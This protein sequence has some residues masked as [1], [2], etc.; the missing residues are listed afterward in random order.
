MKEKNNYDSYRKAMSKDEYFT[1]FKE[2][3]VQKIT[4]EIKEELYQKY[5]VKCEVFQRDSFK[6]QNFNC[7]AIDSP[8]TMHHIKWQKN[9]GKDKSRN[10]VI[11]CQSCHKNYH[12]GKFEGK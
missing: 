5:L 7:K 9:N 2:D 6:C 11:L 1:K 10:C 8:L 3:D 4:D 12:R